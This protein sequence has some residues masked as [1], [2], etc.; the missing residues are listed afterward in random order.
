MKAIIASVHRSGSNYLASVLDGAIEGVKVSGEDRAFLPKY[1]GG[2]EGY[3]AHVQKYIDNA[4][5]EFVHISPQ[6]T[7]ISKDIEADKLAFLIRNPY[8]HALSKV[9]FNP[10]WKDKF[11]DSLISDIELFYGYIA[12]G[13]NKIFKYESLD[14]KGI[15]SVCKWLL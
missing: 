3:K 4:P 10:E 5:D 11:L 8:D 6:F 15:L 9:N 7:H 14:K 12:K 2:E 13:R 1:A